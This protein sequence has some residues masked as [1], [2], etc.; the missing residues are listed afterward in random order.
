MKKTYR[1]KRILAFLIDMM[2]P[3]G[4]WL[5]ALGI[6]RLA[7]LGKLAVILFAAVAM[8]AFACFLFRDYLFSGRSLGKRMLKLCVVDGQT[9]GLPTAKQLIVKDLGL[10]MNAIDLAFL[11]ATGKSLGERISLTAVVGEE[12]LPPAAVAS[13]PPIKKR[14]VK[15]A[16]ASVCVALAFSFVIFFVLEGVKRGDDY[17]MAY[18]YLL[19]S[20]AVREMGVPESQIILT[21][22]SSGERMNDDCQDT[23][24]VVAFTFLVQGRQFRVVCHGQ[25]DQL[26]VCPVCT[27]FQ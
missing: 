15:V 23:S 24:R 22:Y 9:H 19:E 4:T 7:F 27:Q 1:A 11:L 5:L 10:F 14:L 25:G 26:T 8:P 13:K 17:Q 3:Y 6:L 12:M 20:D 2:I 21:G 18:A 16:V